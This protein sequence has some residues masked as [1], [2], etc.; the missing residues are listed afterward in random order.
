MTTVRKLTLELDDSYYELRKPDNGMLWMGTCIYCGCDVA[1]DREDITTV[2]HL[3]LD[4]KTE[5]DW[6]VEPAELDREQV[7]ENLRECKEAV[8]DCKRSIREIKTH[9]GKSFGD[10]DLARSYPEELVYLE[11]AEKDLAVA[12]K[13]KDKI[14]GKTGKPE[15]RLWQSSAPTVGNGTCQFCL[16]VVP[17]GSDLT[18]AQRHGFEDEFKDIEECIGGQEPVL[19]HSSDRVNTNYRNAVLEVLAREMALDRDLIDEQ[20]LVKFN[21]YLDRCRTE[22]DDLLEPYRSNAKELLITPSLTEGDVKARALEISYKQAKRD[23]AIQRWPD[24]ANFTYEAVREREESQALTESK[25]DS[26]S[27]ANSG[28]KKGWVVLIILFT[29]AIGYLYII[30]NA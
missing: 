3:A 19:E 16:H 1:I 24:M 29:L 27:Q 13:V 28:S 15:K 2:K 6:Q 26:H 23:D 25:S 20:N 8:R 12:Q 17:L 30:A 9:F 21:R 14:K 22:R 18:S 11:A 7:N 10:R 5:C 4:G